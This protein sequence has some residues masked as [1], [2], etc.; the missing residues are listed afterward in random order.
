MFCLKKN[1]KIK[2]ELNLSKNF[3]ASLPDNIFSITIIDLDLDR[4]KPFIT[5]NERS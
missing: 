2:I 4:I 1:T 3:N 5:R